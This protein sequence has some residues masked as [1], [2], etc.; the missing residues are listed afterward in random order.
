[1]S[2]DSAIQSFALLKAIQSRKGAGLDRLG[3]LHGAAIAS[4]AM[5]LNSTLVRL[6]QL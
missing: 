2:R 6:G 5:L 1:M 3:R 4:E